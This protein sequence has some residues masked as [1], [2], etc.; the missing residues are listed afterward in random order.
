MNS[1]KNSQSKRLDFMLRGTPFSKEHGQI[2]RIS[3][4][5]GYTRT[6]VKNWLEKDSLPR[7]P[8]ERVTVAKKLGID[9]IYWEYGENHN[10]FQERPIDD[11][12]IYR[13][14]FKVID[15]QNIQ[16]EVDQDKMTSIKEVIQCASNQNFNDDLVILVE[17]LIQLTIPSK[18]NDL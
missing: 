2:E 12:A 18:E 11:A 4:H 14:I 7:S 9:L 10:D 13:A 5:T 8:E 1:E 17:K 15:E 16:P 3:K 6:A